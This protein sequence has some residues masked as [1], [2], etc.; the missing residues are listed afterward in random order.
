MGEKS[1]GLW[2]PGEKVRRKPFDVPPTV[3]ALDITFGST[4]VC[5]ACGESLWVGDWP[6]CDGTN[7]EA[8]RRG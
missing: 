2:A 3:R 8:H 7:P 6:F 1:R 4:G 5:D